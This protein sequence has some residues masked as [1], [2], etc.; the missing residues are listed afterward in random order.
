MIRAA[1]LDDMENV[2]QMGAKFHKVSQMPCLYDREAFSHMIGEMIKSDECAVFVSRHGMIGGILSPAYI[3]PDWKQAI[4][5]FWWSEDGRGMAL[6]RRFEKWACEHGV[7]EVR[8]S[9]IAG[10]GNADRIYD[11]IGYIKR[12]ISYSK[13]LKCQ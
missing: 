13:V 3:D 11:A 1:R 5:L 7:S 6:L 4:E 12:E 9:S 10:V 2:L 8:M